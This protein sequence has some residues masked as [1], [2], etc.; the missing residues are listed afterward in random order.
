M[1]KRILLVIIALLTLVCLGVAGGMYAYAENDVCY[2]DTKGGKD[3][4]DGKSDTAPL[5]SIEAAYGKL[6]D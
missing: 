1:N 4:N 6:S 5:K 2:L 3:T